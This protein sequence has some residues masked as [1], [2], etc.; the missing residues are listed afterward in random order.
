MTHE[1]NMADEREFDLE[2]AV[3]RLNIFLDML[4]SSKN[5]TKRKGQKQLGP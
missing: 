1:G 2:N 4:R 3:D 5:A